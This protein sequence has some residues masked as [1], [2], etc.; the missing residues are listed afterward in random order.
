MNEIKEIQSCDE[1]IQEF[2]GKEQI[3]HAAHVP[4]SGVDFEEEVHSLMNFREYMLMKTEAFLKNWVMELPEMHGI[5]AAL[6]KEMEYGLSICLSRS[7]RSENKEQTIEDGYKFRFLLDY[8]AFL[9]DYTALLNRYLE[10]AL[11]YAGAHPQA[12]EDG[13]VIGDSVQQ[14]L[15]QGIPVNQPGTLSPVV[16]SFNQKVLNTEEEEIKVF[17]CTILKIANEFPGG[18]MAFL[19]TL[20]KKGW[21]QFFAALI[22]TCDRSVLGNVNGEMDGRHT[23]YNHVKEAQIIVDGLER[24]KKYR[25]KK[26]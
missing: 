12:L 14:T 24:R 19:E 25:P 2:I 4:F 3:L 20:T 15:V 6:N 7:N 22:G 23:W 21:A 11:G 1:L 9:Q 26:K 5:Y 16:Q 13:F 18:L 17:R 10:Y 8:I